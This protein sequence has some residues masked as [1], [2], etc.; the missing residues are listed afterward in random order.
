[1]V[2]DGSTDNTE[3]L[4]DKYIQKDSRFKFF[5]RPNNLVKG[6]NACRNFGFI[7]SK[8]VYINF[9]DSDDIFKPNALQSWL[10][11]FSDTADAVVSQIE[12]IKTAG[13]QSIK[14]NQIVSDNLVRDHFLG[15]ISF[16]VCGPL[17]RRQ[18]LEKQTFLFNDKLR[19][20]DDWD[21]NMR[22][23][24][25]QPSLI[26]LDCALM[27]NRIHDSSLSKERNNLNKE[28]LISYFVALDHNLEKIKK[29]DRENYD[30][31][32]YYVLSRYNLYLRHSLK[33]KHRLSFFLLKKLLIKELQFRYYKAFAR[34]ILGY[35][36]FVLFGKG[37][38]FLKF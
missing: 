15:K 20:G 29:Y 35:T 21:F 33:Y 18:F 4:L 37:L 3:K 13:T 30:I 36:Y 12:F 26:F 8:G 23:L 6:P 11:K 27:Q 17:W 14:Q 7:K 10:E 22:M 24:Y 2:D 19:N 32:T 16:Y 31:F 5:K 25:Q 38:Q 34:T 9:F 1:V 28:E